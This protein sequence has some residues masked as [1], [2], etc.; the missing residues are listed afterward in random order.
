MGF[1]AE[2]ARGGVGGAAEAPNRA[3]A[4]R[5]R[6]RE[7]RYLISKIRRRRR[8]GQIWPNVK[9]NVARTLPKHAKTILPL[10]VS[11]TFSAA[12][13][14]HCRARRGVEVAQ[15]RLLRLRTQLP[16]RADRPPDL[17]RTGR[18]RSSILF[19]KKVEE[20]EPS[21][22]RLTLVTANFV[23]RLRDEYSIIELTKTL[24]GFCPALDLGH[25]ALRSAEEHL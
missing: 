17:G 3:R 13:L 14:R 1:G 25:C 22:R 18:S 16:G 6:R 11:F 23:F 8:F 7:L 15:E 12:R 2:R 24:A 10:P 5:R 21:N 20:F 19:S 9:Q 4:V